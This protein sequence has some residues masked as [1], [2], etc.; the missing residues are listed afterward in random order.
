VSRPLT[1]VAGRSVWA[2]VR[3][4]SRTRSGRV[5]VASAAVQWLRDG[6]GLIKTAAET[7]LARSVPARGRRP[8][9]AFVGS[10]PGTCTRE[11]PW[12]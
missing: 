5:F 10:T 11:A 6:L 3:P 9:P 2:A 12:W 4:P 7:G 8:V 1:T